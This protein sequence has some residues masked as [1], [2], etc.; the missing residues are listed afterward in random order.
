MTMRVSKDDALMYLLLRYVE[1]G[2]DGIEIEGI[3]NSAYK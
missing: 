2:F 1:S 3:I